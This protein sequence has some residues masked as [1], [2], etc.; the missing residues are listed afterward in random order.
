MTA[1]WIRWPGNVLARYGGRPV[2]FGGDYNPEQWDESVWPEDM[3]L[4]REAGVNLVTVGVFSWS[5]LQ[6]TPDR[7]NFGW[8][9]R[10]LDLLHANDIAV[11]LATA[12][13]SPPPWLTT[14]FPEVLPVDREGR[15]MS[16]GGRQAWS[17]SSAVYREHALA[18]VEKMA[19]RYGEH[20]ALALW[21]VSN[22]LG[23]HNARCYGDAGAVAFRSWL[24]ERYRGSLD[25]LNAAWTTSAWSQTYSAWEQIQPPRL[26]FTDSNPTQVLDFDRF[27][28]DQ[29]REQLRAE[30][31]V[32][33]RVTPAV[34]ITTNLVLF[35][36]G[37]NMNYSSWTD[38]MDLI[39]SDHYPRPTSD[40]QVELSFSADRARGLSRGKPWLL[41]ETATGATSWRPVNPAKRPG[42]LRRDVL[43]HLAHGADGICFFQWRA[44][45]AGAER[46]HS[47]MLPHAGPDTRKF[48]EVTALGRELASC[49]DA[50]GSRVV[51]DCALLFS[52][53]SW[54]A[55]ERESHPHNGLSYMETAL[56]WYRS[57]RDAGLTTDVVPPS[58]DLSGYRLIIVPMLYLVSDEDAAA[59]AAATEAGASVIVTYF[60]GIVDPLDRVRLGGYPGAFREL[61]GVRVEEFAPMVEPD[62]VEIDGVT[63]PAQV[64]TWHEEIDL[65]D[66]EAAARYAG[67]DFP[68]APAITRATRGEGEAWYVGVELDAD[69]RTRLVGVIAERSGVT[70]VPR[71]GGMEVVTRRSAGHDYVFLI[72]HGDTGTT[73]PGSGTDLLDGSVH[74]GEV[75][76]PAGGVRV[77]K[78]AR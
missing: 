16:Q 25:E 57:L 20:P 48:R 36:A 5:T 76:V 62:L 52:E 73:V 75:T 66:A 10:V 31:A 23:G 32:L 53:E 70:A 71:D 3:R 17:P 45:R 64:S 38:D 21:H 77:V 43:S 34:P 39:A 50:L 15:T 24:K 18:L 69:A 35:D 59:L 49:A 40:A 63:G 27:S 26:T 44:A 72:N 78:R 7:W 33:R 58:A 74:T 42:Q 2:A 37:K 13:A 61:L 68:G 14:R 51:A 22:E 28:S 54:W 6:P 30:T 1:E 12:T 19:E 67:G 11:D 56:H 9:D 8:L 55:A 4:M 29:L 60:S 41:L 47:A 46:F 65:T